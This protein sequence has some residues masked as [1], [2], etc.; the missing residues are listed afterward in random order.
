M[1]W[2][3]AW[4]S[5]PFKRLF[6]GVLSVALLISA[7]MPWY[8]QALQARGGST[9]WEP[10]L[11]HLPAVDVSLFLF[12]VLY[13][14]VLVALWDLAPRPVRLLRGLLAYTL[15]LCLRPVTMWLFTFEPPADLVP[16][17]DPLTAVFYPGGEPFAKDLFFSGHTASITVL[18]CAVVGRTVRWGLV[19]ATVL[20]AAL[21]LLQHVHWTVDVLVAPVAAIAAWRIAGAVVRR[22]LGATSAGA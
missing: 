14:S 2:R 5:V 16:L 3:E 6:I 19:V 13:G 20:V 7:S 10:L 4:R 1:T 21:V 18:A 22:V 9:P 17:M 12:A 15:V 8:F 11:A